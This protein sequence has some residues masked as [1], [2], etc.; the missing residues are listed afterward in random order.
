LNIE[1]QLIFGLSLDIDGVVV[2]MG[3]DGEAVEGQLRTRK[4]RQKV[5]EKKKFDG[6]R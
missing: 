5:V 6:I 1:L 2:V 4:K 3:A